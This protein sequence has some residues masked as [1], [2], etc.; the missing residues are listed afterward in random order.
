M[1]PSKF[2]E[3]DI[4]KI[5]DDYIVGYRTNDLANRYGCT[6]GTIRRVLR[7]ANI[8][9]HNPYIKGVQLCLGCRELKPLEDFYI[10]KDSNTGLSTQCKLCKNTATKIWI[11]NNKEKFNITHK[12]FVNKHKERLKAERK[13]YR[14]NNPDK[15]R[16]H[17]LKTFFSITI[18]DY[19]KILKYQNGVCIICKEP[20]SKKFLSVDHDHSCCS[21]TKSCGKCIR[22]LLC[23]RCNSGLGMFKDNSSLLKEAIYYLEHKIEVK[24][25][26][27][28]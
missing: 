20:P 8:D 7:K 16:N 23:M 5:I 3:E 27:G 18:D 21:G 11:T 17:D 15:V 9:K 12:R 22:G 19:Y 26:L 13:I 14:K 28:S 2:N 4:K 1:P 24:D 6:R 25:V 10:E